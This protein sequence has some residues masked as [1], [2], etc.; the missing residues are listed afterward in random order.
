MDVFDVLSFSRDK[1]TNRIIGKPS[2]KK[3]RL[4]IRRRLFPLIMKT[5]LLALVSGKS[6]REKTLYVIVTMVT[7]VSSTLPRGMHC[8]TFY[9]Y[10][11][12][13]FK[14]LFCFTLEGK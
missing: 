7:V 13:S 11:G 12:W 6:G 1:G 10:T 4:S 3:A 8:L 5:F 14:F 9:S 2:I